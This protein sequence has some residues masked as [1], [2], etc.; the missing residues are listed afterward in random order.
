MIAFTTRHVAASGV[1]A[2]LVCV[3]TLL[4]TFPIPATQGFFN[5]G[6]VMIMVAALTFGPLVGGIAGGIGS[7]LADMIGGWYSYAPFTLVIKGIEGL[8]AGF[9]LSKSRSKRLP[10]IIVA[11]VV[12]GTEMVLGYFTAQAFILGYGIAGAVAEIPFNIVQAAV[13]GILGIP[14]SLALRTR[15][16][17]DR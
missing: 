5:I 8:L 3:T 13:G 11:W 15:I 9:I 10:V 4:I 6:D 1:M 16:R 2:A 17:L 7:S 12:G 14:I